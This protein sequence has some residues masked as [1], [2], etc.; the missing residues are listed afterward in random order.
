MR[1]EYINKI[2]GKSGIKELPRKLNPVRIG[3]HPANHLV[4]DSPYVGGEAAVIDNDVAGGEG[5][6]LWNRN[7]KVI[8]VGDV[9]LAERDQYALLDAPRVVIECWPYLLTA[10]FDREELECRGDDIA[11]LDQACAE[12]VREVHQGLVA[13]HPAD[14][15]DRAEWLRDGYVLTLE[16]E[17]QQLAGGRPDFPPD[18]LTQTDLGDHLAGVAVR[19]ALLHQLVARSGV[20]A[21]TFQDP[22]EARAWGRQRTALPE[23]E[24]QLEQL[25]A[26]ARSAL[27]LDRLDDLSE[28][29]RKLV[30]GFWVYWRSVVAGDSPPST[31]LRRYLALRRLTKEIKD[32][33]YGFG[34]LE[35]LL[36]DPTVTEIMV[37]DGDH[38][39]IEKNGQIEASGRRFLTDPLTVVQR[40]VAR[41]N[42]QINTS[43]PMADARMPDGSRVNA[44]IPPLALRGPCLTIRRFPRTRITV[45]ELV[46]RHRS[47]TRAACEFLR[48]AVVGRRNVVVAGGTGTGK[49]TMLNCL[50]AFI[51]DKERVVTIEDTAELQLQKEHVV[52]LQARQSNQE[53]SGAVTIRDL[54]RNALRMRPDRIV[55]GECRGGEAID[56]LQAMNT[57]HDGSMTTL[58]ANTPEGVVRRLE[59]LVQQNADTRLPVETI[60]QQ[61]ASAVHLIVQLGVWVEEGRK[62]KG[63]VEIAEV[64]GVEEDGRVRLMPLFRRGG[65][66][67][68]LRPTGYLPS[69]LPDLIDAGLVSDP[70]EFVRAVEA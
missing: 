39:F 19:S 9:V 7:G 44:V 32:L 21:E 3:S 10:V 48:A 17:I 6:R 43:Q 1:I 42:R 33:W 11:R 30:S 38:I 5:W 26:G 40:L 58:H 24:R 69:F 4:L 51:P 47:L 35:D 68:E 28:Q 66:D 8:R 31:R 29:T 18:D 64:A 25:A 55:V 20:T 37:V 46:E 36:E 54:V 52:V 59:V 16:K 49:T 57:G 45:E 27:G 41:A 65:A 67:G 13:L 63:V 12:L 61:V 23:F 50:S 70:V 56:M 2:T 60:H 22:D 14:A 62:R 15:A 34:P 53:G